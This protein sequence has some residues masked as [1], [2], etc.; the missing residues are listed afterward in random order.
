MSRIKEIKQQHETLTLQMQF[1]C[2]DPQYSIYK[3]I[4]DSRLSKE[5]YFEFW[6]IA[7]LATYGPQWKEEDTIQ[8]L[9]ENIEQIYKS[10]KESLLKRVNKRPSSSKIDNLWYLYFA[11][12]ESNL[13]LH[14]FKAGGNTDV[15]IDLRNTI[16]DMY[17]E[18]IIAY[19]RKIAEIEELGNYITGHEVEAERLRK[20]IGGFK[21]ITDLVQKQQDVADAMSQTEKKK[22][23]EL[24]K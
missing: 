20:T 18:F 15:S 12:G 24:I 1:F 5:P 21:I 22:M 4:C 8:E 19:K 7:V 11:S 23:D 14:A 17:V 10:M 9:D 2:L 3:S 16:V 13:L 6:N